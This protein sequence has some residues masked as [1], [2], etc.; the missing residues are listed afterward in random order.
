VRRVHFALQAV[1]PSPLEVSCCRNATGSKSPLRREHSA[2]RSFRSI[3]SLLRPPSRSQRLFTVSSNWP[4]LPG[5][6]FPDIFLPE[7]N[8][9]GAFREASMMFLFVSPSRRQAT[10]N[11]RLKLS[12]GCLFASLTGSWRSLTRSL[13]SVSRSCPS[14]VERRYKTLCER[15]LLGCSDLISTHQSRTFRSFNG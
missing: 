9:H 15:P 10:P 4:S 1:P 3:R 8:R 12:H 13:G 2:I 7:C 5:L 11:Q 6:A 14:K